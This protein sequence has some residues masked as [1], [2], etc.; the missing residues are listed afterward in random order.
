MK[1]F[2]LLLIALWSATAGARVFS[3]K[4]SNFG[5]MLRGTG[6]MSNLGDDAF[7]KSSGQDTTTDDQS[8]YQYGG[9]IAAVMG[10]GEKANFRLGAE[11]VRHHPVKG[12]GKNSSDAELFELES[13]TFVFNPNVAVEIIF[14]QGESTRWY[15]QLGVGYAMVDVENRYAMTA[16]G[17]GELGVG[18]FGE[19]L[20]GT[21]L[22]YIIGVG[23]ETSALNNATLSLEAGYR[24]LKI[25]ELK[26]TG[27]VNNIVSPSGVAKGAAA[28]NHD[29]SKRELDLSGA[30][31]GAALRFYL[32]FL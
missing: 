16:Q 30:F 27:D 19:K 14:D 13:K 23:L 24:Y 20:S 15:G 7:G 22:A 4:D 5:V 26:H 32:H 10:V 11:I 29:G 18:D 9:E 2:G 8:K 12:H 17:A 21:G 28:T 25:S 6:G 1:L 31:V 3:F